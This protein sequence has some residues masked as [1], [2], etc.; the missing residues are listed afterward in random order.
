M[1]QPRFLFLQQH[2]NA[3]ALRRGGFDFLANGGEGDAAIE[4]VIQEED[5]PSG[6]IGQRHLAENQFARGLGSAVIAGDAEAIQ[7]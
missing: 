1:T 3:D 7:F 4:N 2:T 6:D 5:V